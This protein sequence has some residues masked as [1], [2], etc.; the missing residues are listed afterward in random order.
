MVMTQSEPHDASELDASV[1]SERRHLLNVGYRL[2]GSLVEAEDVVQETYVR[3]YALSPTEQHQVANI[4][5]WLTTV[6]SRICL[7]LL[8]SAR[9][10]REVYVGDWIPEPLPGRREA[11]SHPADSGNVD[12]ADRVVLDESVGMALLVVMDSMTPAERVSFVLHDVFGY[13]F[14]EIA[15]I[16]GRTPGACRQL[17]SSG[18]ERVRRA[19][20]GSPPSQARQADVVRRFTHAWQAKDINALIS[21]LDP[22][23]I[24]TA[25]GGGKAVSFLQPIRGREQ[26]AGAWVELAGRTTGMTLLERQV[27]GQPGVIAQHSGRTVTVYAFEVLNDRITRIWAIRNPDKLRPWV[28]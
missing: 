27:N 4:G 2:L 25:D 15:H 17:A 1:M 3:W 12:P 5:A 7:N 14:T 9:V 26:V 21:L 20:H 19:R 22:D 13:P 11:E 6:A 23:V 16:V 24:A 8:A 18:R 28:G 10:R